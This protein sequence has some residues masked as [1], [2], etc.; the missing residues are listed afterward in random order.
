MSPKRSDEWWDSQRPYQSSPWR[1]RLQS[2]VEEEQRTVRGNILKKWQK[3]SEPVS[4]LPWRDKE[5]KQ[6]RKDV[7]ERFLTGEDIEEVL[8]SSRD[9]I[10]IDG[11]TWE[12]HSHLRIRTPSDETALEILVDDLEDQGYETMVRKIESPS[13]SD[14][15]WIAVLIR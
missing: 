6:R 14:F 5:E 13:H 8:G 10:E 15:G 1:Y 9:L 12:I 3:S 11:E 4:I 7:S 2:D